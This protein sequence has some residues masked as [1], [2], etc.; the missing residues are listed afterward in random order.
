MRCPRP[1]PALALAAGLFLLSAHPARA[2][3]SPEESA[4]RMKPAEGLESTLWA[5]EPMVVNPTNIDVDSRGR[6]WVTEGLNYRLSHGKPFKK[7]EGADKVKILEDTDGDGK[8]DKVTVFADNI[9][10]IPMGIAV[11]EKYDKA[12]KYLGAKVYIGNSPDLLV[13]E[14]TDGDDKADKRYP[15]LTGFG[16]VD[17]DHGVHGM[18]LGVDGKL[19]F[20]HGDGCCSDQVDHSHRDQNFDVVDRSGRH[21]SSDQLA[22]TLR[23]DRDGTNFE[24]VADRQRNNYET[25]MNSFGNLFTSDNDDDGNR[26][27]R[28]IWVM[29]GGKYGYRTPG[30]PRHWGEDVPGNVPKL[31]GTG[32]GSPC[33][34]MV[35]EGD[36]L[37]AEYKGAVLEAEAGPRY[38]N[39]FPITRKGA[40]FRT[41][42]KIML[43]S[44]DPWFRPVDVTA[45]P[46]G[47][48]FV[49]DWYDGGVGGHNFQDQTTGRI[50]RVAPTGVKSKKIAYDFTTIPGLIEALKSPVVAT[51]D[52][53]RRGLI[54]RGQEA[55]Q[56]VTELMV[57]ADPAIQARALWTAHGIYGDP[58]ALVAAMSTMKAPPAMV[59]QAA[60]ILGRD[61]ARVG[62]VVYTRP[63][64]DQ[65]PPALK[66]LATFN[67]LADHPDAGVRREV[68]LAL[69]D[70]PTPQAGAALRR[71]AASWDGQDRWYLEALGLAL[72]GREA[73][74]LSDLFDGTLYGPMNVEEEAKASPL[75]LPPYFP[76]DRNEAF[77]SASDPEL[78][79]ANA[80]SKTIGLAWELRRAETLP[81][82]VALLP[83]LATPELQQAADDVIKQLNDPA[84]AVALAALLGR[85]ITDPARRRQVLSTLA[86]KIDGPWAAARENVAVVKAIVDTLADPETRPQAIMLAAATGDPRYADTLVKVVGDEKAG[87]ASR[88]A[89]VEALGRIKPPGTAKLL[90]DLIAGARGGKPAD[91]DAAEAAVRTLPRL[92]D[93]RD[94][95]QA[96]M[97]AA[98][99]PLALRREALRTFVGLGGGGAKLLAMATDK[100]LPDA[101]KTEATSVLYGHP[102][103]AIRDQAAKVLPLTTASGKPL[104]SLYEL[105][106]REGNAQ[107]GQDVFFKAGATACG[108]CH[109]VQGRGQW[110]G[111]DLSTIGTKYDRKELLN[112][113]LSPSAAISYNYR[114]AILALADG[115]VVTGL[116]VEESA[117]RIVLKTAE[118]KRITVRPGEVEAR[119][120]G[121]V[122][123]MP[124]GLAQA[125]GE[126]DLVDLLAYLGTLKQ[127]VSI[128]GRAEVLAVAEKDGPA[129]DPAAKFDASKKVG[130]ASWRRID[131]DAEGRLDLAASAG[132]DASKVVYI[133]VPVTSA[134]D[135]P[136][137]LVIDAPGPVRAWLGG[138]EITLSEATA[139]AP[140]S[141]SLTIPK[142]TGDLLI[143][144]GGPSLVATFVAD[145]P[146]EFGAGEAKVSSR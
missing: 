76:V 116:P 61:L 99:A 79:P 48:V 126:R 96:L 106:R 144:A 15:L 122:S 66:N 129:I 30:S 81:A 78:P 62:K 57:H 84:G 69:R 97:A 60:R 140:R 130:D 25:C 22:N 118:G 29:E 80:L 36:L 92:G 114:T 127:P 113:I 111:P 3:V 42:H 9:Y 31:V 100:T 71:L 107:K 112:N 14:D 115:Q 51:R 109:R 91:L 120:V 5:A 67:A 28:V 7:I 119:K 63:I 101:L 59:E 138:K 20:T 105:V 49:A 27:S 41:E 46:D 86:K 136:S 72:R 70:V 8:A 4:K 44:D 13:L 77:I 40:A 74:F 98:D 11:E 82:I 21:V 26:G 89:A 1:A 134:S 24:I 18:V 52:A 37:P 141:A 93:A 131:A 103:R 73:K 94:R 121:D 19:Y 58:V 50:Y 142:G 83:R 108:T 137:R 65:Q 55:G 6:V 38:I 39:Y 33:G 146:V 2:Q 12:G 90:D 104:P 124:E 123:L 43:K 68:I 85:E 143:R 75:A 17:S 16:G 45:A 110:V 64:A 88:T 23:V 53:A 56:A 32:N 34:V 133:H 35:Y 10:P 128:V 125:L 102:D 139:D 145:K 47:S 135:L 95:L 132:A 117:E 54:A 87:V